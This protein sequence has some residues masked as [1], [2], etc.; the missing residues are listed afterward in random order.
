M[1]ARGDSVGCYGCNTHSSDDEKDDE[2]DGRRLRVPVTLSA[3][4]A[5]RAGV[6]THLD[7]QMRHLPEDLGHCMLSLL[8]F[9][10]LTVALRCVG[11][12]IL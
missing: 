5:P 8:L 11:A 4:Q 10:Y 12:R 9:C 3:A 2:T 1:H 6:A 7:V